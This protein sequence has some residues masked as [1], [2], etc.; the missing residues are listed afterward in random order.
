MY[1]LSAQAANEE[2]G[3]KC[4]GGGDNCFLL[5]DD[6][7]ATEV[8]PCGTACWTPCM[9]ANAVT[10]TSR[11]EPPCCTAVSPCIRSITGRLSGRAGAVSAVMQRHHL[12]L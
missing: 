5:N 9:L 8:R 11:A 10:T 2:M 1:A 4:T 12:L 6:E 7:E 3:A